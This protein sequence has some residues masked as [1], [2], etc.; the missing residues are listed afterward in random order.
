MKLKLQQ[1]HINTKRYKR[2]RIQKKV[3]RYE[4]IRKA[5]T[6]TRKTKDKTEAKQEKP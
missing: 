4:K 3:G 6:W 1:N 2:L 5:K